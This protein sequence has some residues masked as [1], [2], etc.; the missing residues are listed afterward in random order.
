MFHSK[1]KVMLE[2][3]KNSVPFKVS[4]KKY[5]IHRAMEV[6]GL[7]VVQSHISIRTG[8]TG[9]QDYCLRRSGS[10][11][12]DIFQWTD[13]RSC[14]PL[15]SQPKFPKNFQKWIKLESTKC[16]NLW[17]IVLTST[18]H[19][20]MLPCVA[21]TCNR[22]GN[23]CSNMFFNLQC[24]ISVH[25]KNV[26]P[27]TCHLCPFVSTCTSTPQTTPFCKCSVPENVH[28]HPHNRVTGNFKGLRRNPPLPTPFQ[29]F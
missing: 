3:T 18:L 13:P 25:C 4:S 10:L 19:D 15:T 17:H 8:P 22:G 27:V 11:F 29:H 1:W 20:N 24:S 6:T 26:P 7:I 28:A 2:F 16:W 14:V 5:L 12:S 21:A 23:V 9:K